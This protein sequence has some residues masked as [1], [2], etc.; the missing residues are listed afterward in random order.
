MYVYGIA[1]VG[2]RIPTHSILIMAKKVEKYRIVKG[3]VDFVNERIKRL[4]EEGWQPFGSPYY[5]GYEDSH[6]QAMVKY[7]KEST[8]LLSPR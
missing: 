3:N 2:V 5:G 8:G 7:E 6:C 4:I 1:D